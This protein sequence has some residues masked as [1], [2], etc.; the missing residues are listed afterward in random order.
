MKYLKW[1]GWAL[2]AVVA[3]VI[4]D[5]KDALSQTVIACS[6]GLGFGIYQLAK[7]IDANHAQ[8]VRMFEHLQSKMN[9]QSPDETVW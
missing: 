7:T 8:T 4:F 6:L 2:L 3:Y 9:Q 1:A 5:S